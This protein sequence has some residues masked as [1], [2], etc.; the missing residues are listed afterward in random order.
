MYLIKHGS[1]QPGTAA[2]PGAAQRLCRRRN[3]NPER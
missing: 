1:A 2:A 3:D